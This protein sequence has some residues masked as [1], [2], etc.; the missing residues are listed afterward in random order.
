MT[1]RSAPQFAEY[2]HFGAIMKNQS[3][4]NQGNPYSPL[5]CILFLLI[6]LAATQ[7]NIHASW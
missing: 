5:M 3:Q 4:E 6:I 2:I 7:L 1:K